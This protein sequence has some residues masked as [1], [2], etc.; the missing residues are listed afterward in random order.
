MTPTPDE[1]V[2]NEPAPYDLKPIPVEVCG[3]VETRELPAV[4]R[5]GYF[6]AS[7]VTT[8]LAV[9]VLPME[10]RRKYA[11]LLS[12]DQDLWI[13]TSQAGAQSGSAGAMRVPAVIPYPIH[14][15][16]EVWVC[17]VAGTASVGVETVAWSE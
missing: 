11:V 3:P 4:G 5:P 1:I 2:Q 16:H 14:H 7:G 8:T 6:T 13:S 10:P 9:R 17:A 12:A 15:M